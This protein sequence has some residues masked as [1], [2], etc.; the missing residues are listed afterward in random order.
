MNSANDCVFCG[1]RP[2]P[3][4]Y[5]DNMWYVLCGNKACNR[6]D[7]YAYLGTNLKNAVEQWNYINRKI[8][9]TPTQKRKKNEDGDL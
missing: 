7:K 2:I 9:R 3:Y 1:A 8:N 4:H 6:H 5:E